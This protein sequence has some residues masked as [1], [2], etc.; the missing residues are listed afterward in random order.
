MR[1]SRDYWSNIT[2]NKRDFMDVL[3]D[4]MRLQLFT[5][6]VWRLKFDGNG[7]FCDE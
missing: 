6:L 3:K 7:P 1:L 4:Q 2:D 5:S